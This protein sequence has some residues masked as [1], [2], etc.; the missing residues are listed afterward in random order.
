VS[1][2]CQKEDAAASEQGL[3]H[4]CLVANF[5]DLNPGCRKE[6]GRAV[7]MAFFIYAPGSILTAP[8]DV[9]VQEVCLRARPNMLRQPGAVGE[10]LA[11]AVSGRAGARPRKG[12]DKGG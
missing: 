5:D 9:D 12:A 1:Q 7:H 11:D 6:L 2:L 8:C 3:V 4:K 10:C